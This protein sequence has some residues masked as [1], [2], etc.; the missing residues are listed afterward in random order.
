M[1]CIKIPG[2][3]WTL[4]SWVLLGPKG[5]LCIRIPNMQWILCKWVLLG[6]QGILCIRIPN[7][8]GIFC[9]WVL[10]GLQGILCIRFQVCCRH[11]VTTF[12]FD[13]GFPLK[14]PY[15]LWGFCACTIELPGLVTPGFSKP[16]EF[17]GANVDPEIV[18]LPTNLF[19]SKYIFFKSSVSI[20]RMM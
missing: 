11:F 16:T 6:L 4:C 10:L 7:M 8:Q 20:G 2:L 15:H 14:S 9:N 1:L 19:S 13:I 17:G 18:A 3:Q 5:I 12:R